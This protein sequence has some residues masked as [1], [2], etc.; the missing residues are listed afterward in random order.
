MY[1]QPFAVKTA[2][3]QDNRRS[4]IK[5]SFSHTQKRRKYTVAF[6]AKEKIPNYLKAAF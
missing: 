2:Q 4:L 5:D 1:F 3:I 6:L